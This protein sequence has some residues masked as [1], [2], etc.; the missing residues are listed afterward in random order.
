MGKE[1]THKTHNSENEKREH[2]RHH[3]RKESKFALF[4][5]KLAGVFKEIVQPPPEPV[6]IKEEAQE[7][8]D[9]IRIVQFGDKVDVKAE[10]EKA[11][12]E[13]EIDEDD[14]RAKER[15]KTRDMIHDHI[16]GRL[17]EAVSKWKETGDV[18]VHLEPPVPL[19][20]KV[21]GLLAKMK[22]KSA[23][24]SVMLK[25]RAEEVIEKVAV[26]LKKAEHSGEKVNT[27]DIVK[28][29]WTKVLSKVESVSGKS[30]RD[31]IEKIYKQL[32][33]EH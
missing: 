11:A 20:E 18:G 30:E 12:E 8:G 24:L 14:L 29:E 27:D 7:L 6:E 32:S 31:E 25:N 15:E 33:G 13:D 5:H 2:G 23:P 3:E 19:H 26:R 17:N 10:A 9:D 28:E 1:V 4:K 22:T 21:K 16:T